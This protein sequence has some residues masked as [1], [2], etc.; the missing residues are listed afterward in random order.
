[1]VC[2]PYLRFFRARHDATNLFSAA[3][4]GPHYS[5]ELFVCSSSNSF[6]ADG[7]TIVLAN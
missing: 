4:L 2:I 1:M 3:L 5:V 7:E 6:V